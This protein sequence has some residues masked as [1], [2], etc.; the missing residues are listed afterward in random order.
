MDAGACTKKKQTVR[1]KRVTGR[2]TICTTCVALLVQNY[3]DAGSA[4]TVAYQLV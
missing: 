1:F 3:V 2:L 4:G